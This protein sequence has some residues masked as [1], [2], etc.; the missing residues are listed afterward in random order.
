[1]VVSEDKIKSF[2]DENFE[3]FMAN[4]MKIEPPFKLVSEYTL[5]NGQQVDKV[6]MGT[7]NKIL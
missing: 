6:I 3:Q 7:N 2:V 5:S 1:M 4:H